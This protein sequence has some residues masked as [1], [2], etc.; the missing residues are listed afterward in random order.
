MKFL[1]STE[2]KITQ[3]KNGESVPYLK[4]TEV[5]LVHCHI[6]NDD[7]QQDSRL[8]YKFVPNKPFVSLSEISPKNCIFF[9]TFNSEFQKI[10][11]LQI[12]IFNH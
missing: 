5:V 1:G 7:Y 2:I 12:K 6:I 11:G 10:Y 4:I 9:R 8:S 3:D